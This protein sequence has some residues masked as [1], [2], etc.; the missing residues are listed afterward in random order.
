MVSFVAA[1]DAA[2]RP[3]VAAVKPYRVATGEPISY[4]TGR[5]GHDAVMIRQIA[6][7][8]LIAAGRS[9]VKPVSALL[10]DD[11]PEVRGRA[12]LI[13]VRLCLSKNEATSAAA[14]AALHDLSEVDSR[15]VRL[16]A[17]AAAERMRDTAIATLKQQG[18]AVTEDSFSDE[19]VEY[20]VDMSRWKGSDRSLINLRFLGRITTLDL[21]KSRINDTNIH[22]LTAHRHIRAIDLRRTSLTDKALKHLAGLSELT[23]IDLR[24][25]QV[26]GDGLKYL[27]QLKKL[28]TVHLG[29]TQLTGAGLKYICQ[30]PKLKYLNLSTTRLS[31]ADLAPLKRCRSLE[32]LWLSHTEVGDAGLRSLSKLP[33]LKALGLSGTKITDTGLKQLHGL[34]TLST[35]W[36][37]STAVTSAGVGKLQQ[38]LPDANIR[39]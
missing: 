29:D 7:R 8:K 27:A 4:W 25:T 10:N 3:P 28:E 17:L 33:K 23:E 22:W 31:N 5:L 14:L 24:D 38:A 6:T 20:R 9:A 32:R 1:A 34:K 37:T 12:R 2:D 39:H 18:V 21:T 19:G 35:I 26:T 13:L 36:L 15:R 16:W 30:A 11:D